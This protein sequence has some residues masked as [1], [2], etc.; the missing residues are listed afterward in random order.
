MVKGALLKKSLRDM[1]NSKAQ[2]ISI[3]IMATLAVSLMTGL[4]SIWFTVQN[5]ADAMY[6]AT[7]L[8]DLW[9]TVANPSEQELRGI[10]KIPGVTEVEKRFSAEADTDLPGK[11]TLHVY[12]M[13]DRS[14]LDQPEMQE[15][16]FS[17]IGGSAVL[18]SDFA[19]AHN[20]KVGDHFSI[21]LN[22]VWLRLSIDGL[23]LNSEQ[24]YAVKKMLQPLLRIQRFTAL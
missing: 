5:H 4:D 2:F 1:H 12:A 11:P 15:G 24:I 7:N 3:F 8:S 23:A 20:L 17:K 10:E 9:V 19:K 22:G 6:H 21:K 13:E 18:D 16:K 14:T